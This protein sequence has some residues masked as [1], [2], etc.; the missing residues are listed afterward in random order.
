MA[1]EGNI[2]ARITIIGKAVAMPTLKDLQ[3]GIASVIAT[4]VTAATKA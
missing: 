3:G 1:A 4:A 2:G